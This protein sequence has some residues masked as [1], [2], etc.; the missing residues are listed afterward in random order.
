MASSAIRLDDTES[1]EPPVPEAAAATD[2]AAEA[3]AQKAE[4][5]RRQRLQ[6]LLT[7]I[8]ANPDF[9]T[10]RESVVG[11]QRVARSERAHARALV[12]LLQDDPAMTAKLLRLVNAA[13]YS[14]AGGGQITNLQR[15]VALVGFSGMG[16][17]ATSLMMFEQLPEGAAGD[18]LRREFARAQLA[19]IV[20]HEFCHDRRYID[21]VYIAALFQRLGEFLAGLHVGDEVRDIEDH[22]D[23]RELAP[24]SPQRAEA[25]RR[26]V[27][28]RW[29]VSLEDIAVEAAV[30][31]GWPKRL[32]LAMRPLPVDDP[33]VEVSDDAYFRTL[34]TAANELSDLL[35]HAPPGGTPEEQAEARRALTAPFIER[36]ATALSLDPDAAFARIENARQ[37]WVDLLKALGVR[38]AE[39]SCT[40][41]PDAPPKPT[42]NPHSQ[43][44][45][46]ELAARLA[47]AIEHLNRMNRKGAPLSEVLETVLRLLRE[48]MGLQRA[49]ACLRDPQTPALKGHLGLGDRAGVLTSYF[50]I[51][52]DPP[53][54][55]FGVLC[56]RNADAL[57]SDTRD[58]VVSQRLPPWFH[59]KVKAGSFVLLPLVRDGIV[60]GL[61]YG[62]QP[63]PN[64]LVIHDRGLALLKDLRRQVVRAMQPRSARG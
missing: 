22:L 46:Q 13:Y 8:E 10:I 15:A 48:A 19:A 41:G 6:R 5:A 21:S 37:S 3:E 2:P 59:Q 18:R 36:H 47:D 52:L 32:Q 38:L 54:D 24:L 25:R 56:A 35:M 63:E 58:P 1:P 7:R 20:A 55:L 60:V 64:Q 23:D 16:L 17:L 62:D 9:A 30:R 53:S 12:H 31:W 57:I 61:L 50:D 43:A 26:L 39:A 40:G 11:V 4:A 34:C 42:V 29:G 33:Q 14:A 44:Y 27:L 28:D 49:V 45:R 51:P